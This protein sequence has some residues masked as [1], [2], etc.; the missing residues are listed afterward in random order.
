[1]KRSLI[2]LFTILA[3]LTSYGQYEV[4]PGSDLSMDGSIATGRIDTLIPEYFNDTCFKQSSYYLW[5][6]KIITG[7]VKLNGN[8]SITHLGQ[9]FDSGTDSIR[10]GSILSELVYVDRD[11][12]AGQIWASIYPENDLTSPIAQSL[13]Q[14]ASTLTDTGNVSH[15]NDFYFSVPPV[16]QGRFWVVF[17][18]EDQG[19]SI[20]MASTKLNCGNNSAIFYNGQEWR[21]FKDE[22]VYANQVLN[23]GLK[24]AVVKETLIS[25]LEFEANNYLSFYPNPS[26]GSLMVN[27]PGTDQSGILR[28]YSSSGRELMQ[29]PYTSGQELDLSALP[30]GLYLVEFVNAANAQS[31]MG[32]LVIEP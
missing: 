29:L 30:Q 9:L 32:R 14:S 28:L 26:S 11:S 21:Y 25:Q 23:I 22:F 27:L 15:F 17:N 13:P 5:Q 7:P 4:M 8:L 18:V 20:F 12:G 24:V 10:I 31:S 1:M 3:S 2:L 6:Q 19:D 16:V